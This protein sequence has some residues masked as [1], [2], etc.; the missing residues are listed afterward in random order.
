MI[1]V[2][3][4]NGQL[5]SELLACFSGRGAV[6]LTHRDVEIADRA[7]VER[8]LRSA[9]ARRE[10]EVVVINTAAYNLVDACED[11][12]AP[13]HAANAQGA[14]HVAAVACALGATVVHFSTD[15]VFDGAKRS[16]YVET[17][18]PNPLNVY[19]R[20]KL[21][22]ERAVAAA[23][24][25]HYILR[26]GALYG[27]A[28]PRKRGENFVEMVLRRAEE[29]RRTGEP[30]RAV[31]DQFITPTFTRSVAR[32]VAR[33][34]GGAPFGLYHATN[35]GGCTWYEC[36]REVLALAGIEADVRPMSAAELGRKAQR[37]AYSVLENRAL[38]NLG[39]DVMEDW[40]EAL[41][42]Y[43]RERAARRAGAPAGSGPC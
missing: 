20:S 1:L 4:A 32:Q 10:A 6:G 5:G 16:P 13:A 35:G 3:G 34:L 24:P 7:S 14:G 37:P 26:V 33:L 28:P 30:V 41:A 19:G 36:A 29:S 17:D 11:D 9:L 31:N 38:M 42:E 18:A 43:L 2:I 23:N 21:E 12:A 8:A 39:L 15:Y 25:R 27:F 22:G 40:R